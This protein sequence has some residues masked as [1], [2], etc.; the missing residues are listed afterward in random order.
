MGV[1]Y[2]LSFNIFV[3]ISGKYKDNSTAIN[4]FYENILSTV[5]DIDENR[6][7]IFPPVRI[8]DP[9]MLSDLIIPKNNGTIDNFTMA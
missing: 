4:I 3:E 8:S 2:N 6:I 9:S 1:S 7:L 5:R